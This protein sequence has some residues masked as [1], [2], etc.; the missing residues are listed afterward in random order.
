M[1]KKQNLEGFQPLFPRNQYGRD[2]GRGLIWI[3]YLT[4]RLWKAERDHEMVTRVGYLTF[5]HAN[6]L[7]LDIIEE[8]T[9]VDFKERA[10]ESRKLYIAADKEGRDEV[11]A[12]AGRVIAS[13]GCKSL[14]DPLRPPA[15]PRLEDTVLCLGIY[16]FYATKRMTFYNMFTM[17]LRE[18][19]ES[20]PHDEDV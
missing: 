15:L 14:A 18:R 3:C 6:E 8:A 5:T 12:F 7:T 17:L 19:S 13:V 16:V 1:G 9:G 10:I 2:Y 20:F 11:G 4:A